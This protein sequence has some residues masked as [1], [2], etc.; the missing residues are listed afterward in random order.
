MQPL[1]VLVFVLLNG[2]ALIAAL[3][4]CVRVG[5]EG[6]AE[7][8]LGVSML[9]NALVL[10]PV[11]ATGVANVLTRP[12]LSIAS[13]VLSAATFAL[14]ARGHGIEASLRAAMR[15]GVQLGRAP[16]EILRQ[17]F[18][19]GPIA[20]AAW[21]A[22]A[23]ALAWTLALVY[24]APSE[25]W[26]G[27]WYHDTMVGYAIQ[28]HG[29]APA[30][31][32]PTDLVQQA[33]GYP[34][35]SEMSALWLVLFTDRR[36]IELPNTLAVVPLALAT[37]AFCRR[38]GRGD[39]AI[40]FLWGVAIVLFPGVR[41]EMRT[42]Y[43]DNFYAA[44]AAASFYFATHPKMD[45]RRGV[46]ASVALALCLGSKSMGLMLVPLLAVIA[47]AILA[48]RRGLAGWKGT[49]ATGLVAAAVIVL[50]GG[51]KYLLNWKQY[52]NPFFPIAL[53]VAGHA[54][55][56]PIQ[57]DSVDVSGSNA[58]TFANLLA[59]PVPGHDFVDTR[60]Y[61]YGMSVGYVLGPTAGLAL[62]VALASA[63]PGLASAALQR[64]RPTSR[65]LE[66]VQVLLV[67]AVALVTLWKSP[68]LWAARYNVHAVVVAMAATHWLSHRLARPEALA[69]G[70]AAA[71]FVTNVI[72]WNWSQPGWQY[73]WAQIA[74]LARMPPQERAATSQ[75]DV[76]S[77]MLAR[78]RELGDGDVVV[79][80]D[81]LPFPS[82]LWNERMSN[83]LEYVPSGDGTSYV[84][85][86][87]R[88]GAKWL[89]VGTGNPAMGVVQARSDRWQSVGSVHAHSQ[90]PCTAF[91][92]IGGAPTER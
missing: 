5:L 37:A 27:V 3:A 21:F 56:G 33:N 6:R 70:A 84:D 80:S 57:L 23:F 48:V 16:F 81:D 13:V 14:A 62:I 51:F 50:F 7:R 75:L 43:C 74:A 31:L 24:L 58:Q 28:Q 61:G 36:F 73:D 92:R 59:V 76:K 32:P 49:A 26:D 86:A 71:C 17:C 22:L 64:R 4:I 29:Y 1:W 25:S 41:L 85:Q 53:T 45:V 79:W 52:G 18:R 89:V 9:W 44:W 8:A 42:T 88:I 19:H 2:L 46:L 60:V 78:E 55:P 91:R 34:R 65:E 40:A 77:T 47:L 82:L 68:A 87:E 67:G 66:P 69:T 30:Y 35:D 72:A 90:G 38:W 10:A 63:I 83:H 15:E 11:H 39:P 54:F 20:L 12:T